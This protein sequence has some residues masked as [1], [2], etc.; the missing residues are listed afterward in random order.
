MQIGR[1]LNSKYVRTLQNFSATCI[2]REIN[3]KGGAKVLF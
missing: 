1:L 2:L 3:I